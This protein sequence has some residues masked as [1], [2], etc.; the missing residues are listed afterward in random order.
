MPKPKKIQYNG[1]SKVIAALANVGNWLLDNA[2]SAIPIASSN[3][4]GGI[5]VGQNLTIENDGTLNAEAGGSGVDV[6][7]ILL[8]GTKIAEISITEG[9]SETDY[10]IYAPTPD[11]VYDSRITI[12][13]NDTEVDNFTLNQSSNKSI[14]ISVPTKTSDLTNDSGFITS[15]TDEKITAEEKN[16]TSEKTYNIPFTDGTTNQKP[17]INDGIKYKTLQGTS[18]SSGIANLVLGNDIASG[19]AGNKYGNLRIYS[20]SQYF[21]SVIPVNNLTANRT[22]TLP[23]KSGTAATTDDIPTITD[24]YDGTSSDGMSGKAVKSAIDALDGSVTGSAAASKTLTAFSQTN[25]VVSATFADISIT[26]SQVSDFPT[27]ATVATSGAYNDLSGKPTIPTVYNKTITI[28]KNSTT[29][30]SFTLNQS[31]DK[32]INISVPTKT[33]DLTNDSGFITSYTDEKVTGETK[34]PTSGTTYNVLFTN[35]TTNQK[36]FINDGLRVTTL[37]GTTSAAGYSR[38]LVG[39][40]TATGTAGNKYGEIRLFSEKAGFAR[41][42]MT[43]AGT[44]ERAIYFPD[45]A[46]TVALTS[47]LSSYIAKSG[48]TMTGRLTMGGKPISQVVTGSGTV[49]QDKGSG[50]TNRYVPSEWVFNTGVTVA[51]GDIFTI[52]IPVAGISYGVWVSMDNGTTYY[53]VAINGT[54]R[55]GTQYGA[56]SY[57]TLQY[58]NASSVTVYARGGSDSSSSVTKIFRVLNFYNSDTNTQMRI[59]RQNTSYN[60]DYPLIASRTLASSIGTAGTNSSYSAVYGVMWDDTTKVPT[61]NPSTG[62]IKAVKFTGTINGTLQTTDVAIASGD[63]LVICDSSDSNKI[64]RSSL[65]FGT[66]TSKFLREDGTWQTVSVSWSG[67]TISSDI[68]PNSDASLNLGAANKLFTNV[69]AWDCILGRVSSKTGWIDF[70]Q[71]TDAYYT[72][73]MPNGSISKTSNKTLYLPSTGGTLLSDGMV[74]DAKQSTTVTVT[75]SNTSQTIYL[76]KFQNGMKCIHF[77][78][79]NFPAAQYTSSAGLIPSDYRPTTAHPSGSGLYFTGFNSQYNSQTVTANKARSGAITNNGT[80][81]IYASANTGLWASFFYI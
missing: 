30:D 28:Q 58:E 48:D 56:N 36:P 60:N 79:S 26:K 8:S 51:D 50:Q 49:G 25:G 17:F 62:E 78:S 65:A 45:K 43:A 11:T 55:L 63:K 31:T 3:S 66:G 39:N 16:P 27:L 9:T 68:I 14:N 24:T 18:G 73:L 20:R 34:N 76:Y 74:A 22:F 40:G 10:D 77:Q 44:A 71:S 29:V 7:P 6:T 19:T 37:Q 2:L 61:L 35:S 46:G 15:Y 70:Y 42:R 21:M 41:L 54:T 23:D 33:S 59:Y 80:L 72:R 13:K 47:D 52:K 75:I 69:Y 4:L 32:T 57:L 67:G 5:K 81:Y 12:R 38:L 53:P 1:D 64:A